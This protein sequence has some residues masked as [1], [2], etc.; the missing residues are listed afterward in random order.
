MLDNRQAELLQQALALLAKAEACVAEALDGSDAG[1][2][3]IQD[4]NKIAQDLRA[5]LMELADD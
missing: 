2:D 5:D 4:I 3:T 1:T